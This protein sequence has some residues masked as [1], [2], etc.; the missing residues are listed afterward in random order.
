MPL[1]DCGILNLS[2][3][4]TKSVSKRKRL[5]FL[6]DLKL[7]NVSVFRAQWGAGTVPRSLSDSA[8]QIG[9]KS[10]PQKISRAS[11][12]TQRTPWAKI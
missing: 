8:D 11:N 7:P 2:S 10:N 6:T 12:K 5:D 3:T 9:K 4:V 1:K